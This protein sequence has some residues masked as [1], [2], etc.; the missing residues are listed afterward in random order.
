MLSNEIKPNSPNEKDKQMVDDLMDEFENLEAKAKT[1]KL[2]KREDN[3][4]D[5][6]KKKKHHRHRSPDSKHDRKKSR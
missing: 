5:Y 2:T 4:E 6:K 3:D 1:E